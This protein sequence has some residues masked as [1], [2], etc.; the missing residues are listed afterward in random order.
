MYYAGIGSR[1]T[2]A[3]ITALMTEIAIWMAKH[4]WI[5][6]SGGAEGADS[7]FEKGCDM[8]QGQKEIYLPWEGFNLKEGFI[9]NDCPIKDKAFQLAEKV[10]N[11]RYRD[12][13]VQVPWERL[14]DTTKMLMSRNC[15]QIGGP[16]FKTTTKLV[17]CW[18]SDGKESGGTGQALRLATML[19]VP[20]INLYNPKNVEQVE[21]W[22]DA[23]IDPNLTLYHI[24]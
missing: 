9:L 11:A 16:D 22:I 17:V 1:S 13:K 14:K 12:K 3:D 2:P 10:W 5:L 23:D 4:C 24:G 8:S 18:T 20:I 7:A 21:S 6:R 19:K 15:F